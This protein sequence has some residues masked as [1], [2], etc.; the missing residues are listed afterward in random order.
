MSL[1][2]IPRIVRLRLEKIQ[3]EF[4]W[5]EGAL[6]NK[7]HLVMRLTVCEAKS[8]GGLGIRSLSLLNKALLC[9]WCWH[10]SSERDSLWKKI[11]KGKFGRKREDGG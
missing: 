4:L 7:I 9:K 1:F 10:F 6:D 2:T 8:K 11:T 5:G 3:K